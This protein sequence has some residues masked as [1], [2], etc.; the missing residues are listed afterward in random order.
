MIP[1]EHFFF[2]HPEQFK[3]APLL[4]SLREGHL[5]RKQQPQVIS[6]GGGLQLPHA[7]LCAHRQPSGGFTTHTPKVQKS[8]AALLRN[9]STT[10][11]YHLKRK[12]STGFHNFFNR[13]DPSSSILLRV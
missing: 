3:S 5:V 4:K 12:P 13:A 2:T 10:K 6:S 8:R 11:K 9:G 1:P 7:R